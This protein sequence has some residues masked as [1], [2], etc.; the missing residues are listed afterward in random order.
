MRASPAQPGAQ[1]AAGERSPRVAF[2]PAFS[3]RGTAARPA[4]RER[5]A[6]A[7]GLLRRLPRQHELRRAGRLSL[8]PGARAGAPGP[9]RRRAGRPALPRADAL[10]ALGAGAPRRPVLGQVVLQR[11]PP[12]AA[13]APAPRL[14]AAAL[15]R[16]RRE[17][18][19]LPA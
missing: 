17:P 7:P 11:P 1:R 14:R 9:P 6:P 5:R 13:R 16:A 12:P 19:G 4:P 10:R 3:A 2:A 8:A 15:L 18:H